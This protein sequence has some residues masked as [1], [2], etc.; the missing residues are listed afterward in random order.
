M[1]K[2]EKE[3]ENGRRK[4]KTETETTITILYFFAVVKAEMYWEIQ[5]ATSL[6]QGV[7]HVH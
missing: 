2:N 1:E 7:L 5:G 4:R 6:R 3:N